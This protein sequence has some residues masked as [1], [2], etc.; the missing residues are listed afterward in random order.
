LPFSFPSMADDKETGHLQGQHGGPEETAGKQ[1]PKLSCLNINSSLIHF[2]AAAITAANQKTRGAASARSTAGRAR[3]MVF[4]D[5]ATN[6]AE[7]AT[8]HLGTGA[9]DFAEAAPVRGPVG[10]ADQL[11][12]EAAHRAALPLRTRRTRRRRRREAHSAR[13]RSRGDAQGSAKTSEMASIWEQ[14]HQYM[15]PSAP[16][17]R[18]GRKQLTRQ[19]YFSGPVGLS[20]GVEGSRAGLSGAVEDEYG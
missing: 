3:A 1:V 5:P 18:S 19:R 16:R 8:R 2:G 12:A 20:G 15:V 11:G 14:Q 17:T 7:S 4:H 6:L 13:R 9:R 10:A